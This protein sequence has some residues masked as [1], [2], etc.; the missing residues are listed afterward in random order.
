MT[1]LPTGLWPVMIT[2]FKNNNNIDFDNVRRVTDM[3]LDSGASGMFANCLSSEMFQLTRDERLQLT[4]TVVDHCKGKVPVVATG[5][6]YD[7]GNDNAD[8]IKEIYDIGV[9]AVILISSMLVE[10]EESDEVLKKNIE[11]ILNKTGDIPLGVY[12][13]PVPYKR[14]ISPNMMKWLAETD[15]FLYFKDTTCDGGAIKNKLKNIE[16]SNFHLYNAD[17]PTALESLRDGGKGI[18]PISGNFY[19]EL[20]GHFL[21]LFAAEENEALERLNT[22]LTVMDK[23]TDDFYPWSAKLFLEKRG[24]DICTNT[25]IPMRK[26][27]VKDKIILDALLKMFHQICDEFGI[28]PV[29]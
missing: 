29:I 18:S 12:E 13:C 3:Y 21:K 24:L 25:R 6:F 1:K 10:P 27:A 22:K 26:M 17:T 19:P 4:K 23:V 8:F 28:D 2:P 7:N 11:L 9:D 15:R 16:G 20:Y 5:S 14:I